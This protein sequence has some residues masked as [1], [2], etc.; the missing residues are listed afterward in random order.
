MYEH[1]DNSNN[2]NYN[3]L[4]CKYLPFPAN[5]NVENDNTDTDSIN[6]ISTNKLIDNIFNINI[7]LSIM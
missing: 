5:D 4:C 7:F 6:A 2:H 1:Y 3:I